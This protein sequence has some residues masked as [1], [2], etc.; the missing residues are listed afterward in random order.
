[1]EPALVEPHKAADGAPAASAP[2]HAP[3]SEQV[4]GKDSL[5]ESAT[6]TKHHGRQK[7]GG[8]KVSFLAPIPEDSPPTPAEWDVSPRED[9]SS[10]KK[11]RSKD[12]DKKDKDKDKEKDKEKEK[13]KKHKEKEKQKHTERDNKHEER[14]SSKSGTTSPN[15][16]RSRELSKFSISTP[17]NPTTASSVSNKE[18]KSAA[19]GTID[20]LDAV[21]DQLLDM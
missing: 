20:D 17:A 9:S 13:D 2:T 1:V 11:S 5:V 19:S 14:E 12:K 8:E 21:V 16:R 3:A 7:S 6:R 18:E 4:A 10:E 15:K